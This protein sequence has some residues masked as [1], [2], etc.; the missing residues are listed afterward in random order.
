[1]AGFVL[2]VILTGISS[3]NTG[4]E[5]DF[6]AKRKIRFP[7]YMVVRSVML[8]LAGIVAGL[9]VM[10][11]DPAG[12]LY[13]YLA[14]ILCSIILIIT[15]L[16]FTRSTNRVSMRKPAQLGKRGGDEDE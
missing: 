5:S 12:D 2:F 3:G 7:F 10:I 8:P 16:D 13:F 4:S 11:I 14:S 9:I 6:E 15:V 1:M